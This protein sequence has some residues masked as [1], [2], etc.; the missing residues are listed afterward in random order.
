MCETQIVDRA[1][2][3]PT[4]DSFSSAPP[5]LAG[6]RRD[7]DAIEE[8]RSAALPG[9][10]K[11]DFY[12]HKTI[13]LFSPPTFLPNFNCARTNHYIEIMLLDFL[14]APWSSPIKQ[15][16]AIIIH[17]FFFLFP[18]RIRVASSL[19]VFLALTDDEDDPE[20]R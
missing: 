6:A 20:V 2:D 13:L 16:L 10:F 11:I 12:C 19:F 1:S 18:T 14:L 9:R 5:H 3:T 4:Q 15:S 17:H 7:K 8:Q